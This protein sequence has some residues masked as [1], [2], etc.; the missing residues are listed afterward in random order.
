[1]M[2]GNAKS[3]FVEGLKGWVESN[4]DEVHELKD[5]GLKIL[6]ATVAVA[7]AAVVV[8]KNKDLIIAFITQRKCGMCDR[9][10]GTLFCDDDHLC[11]NCSMEIGEAAD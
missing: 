5:V 2:S 7:A 6:T 9:G 10:L 11:V 8:K 3:Q 1:M 4:D